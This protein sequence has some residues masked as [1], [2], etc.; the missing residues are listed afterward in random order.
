MATNVDPPNYDPD[1]L[2]ISPPS[3][4]TLLTQ[5]VMRLDR[6]T[7]D[8]LLK[9]TIEFLLYARCLNE[10]I[11]AA[12]PAHMKGNQMIR[13]LPQ[14][15]K[16]WFQKR[17]SILE[18]LCAAVSTPDQPRPCQILECKVADAVLAVCHFT[19]PRCNYRL[20]LTHVYK[21]CTLVSTYPNYPLLIKGEAPVDITRLT[22]QFA[23]DEHPEDELAPYFKGYLSESGSSFAVNGVMQLGGVFLLQGESSAPKTKRRIRHSHPYP[24]AQLQEPRSNSNYL[25]IDDV[26]P[27]AAARAG[28][29]SLPGPSR[30]AVAGPSRGLPAGPSRAPTAGPSRA[31]IRAPNAAEKGLQLLLEGKGVEEDVW[32]A[33]ME[34]CDKCRRFF[35]AGY[36][37][38]KHT[39]GCLGVIEID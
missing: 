21:N 22:I 39:M 38:K 32:D 19:R 7:I 33:A 29:R 23:L 1:P 14:Q 25:E 36:P 35:I 24:Q 34:K 2:F 31:A 30:S 8:V 5:P 9:E 28:R 26:Y 15:L 3:L 18:C 11:S 20:N 27:H 6:D 37:F 12:Y 17:G 4:W 13:I 16:H 10:F